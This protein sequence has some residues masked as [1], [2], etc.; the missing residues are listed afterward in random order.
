VRRLSIVDLATGDQPLANEDG[1]IV[2]VCNGE[3]Y[4]YVELRES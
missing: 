2:V 3:I 4:N 1:T